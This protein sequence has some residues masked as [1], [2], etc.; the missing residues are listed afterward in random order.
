MAKP[1]KMETRG[2][3]ELKATFKGAPP[4]VKKVGQAF[5]YDVATVQSQYIAQQA[6]GRFKNLVQPYANGWTTGVSIGATKPRDLLQ[7]ILKGTRPHPIFARHSWPLGFMWH[8][9][10]VH[11]WSVNHPGTQPNDFVTRGIEKYDPILRK[12]YAEL[13]AQVKRAILSK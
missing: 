10:K 12:K 4:K 9:A 3:T 8:G 11:F 2:F 13:A 1:F 6:P 7:W 5:L